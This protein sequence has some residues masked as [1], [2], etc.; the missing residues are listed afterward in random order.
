MQASMLSYKLNTSTVP[1]YFD[2]YF[3]VYKIIDDDGVYPVDKVKLI[4]EMFPFELLSFYDRTKFEADARG[5]ELTHKL[6]ID[7]FK[8]LNS[9]HLLKINDEWHKVYNVIHFRNKE[10]YAQT[11]ITLV[12]YDRKVEVID[13]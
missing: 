4:V 5:I 1:T 9:L 7:Q 2:G 3:D 12:K 8:E 6:R 10:G 13:N 11:D